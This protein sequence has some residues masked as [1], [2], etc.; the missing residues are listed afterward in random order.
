MEKPYRYSDKECNQTL[1]ALK[2]ASRLQANYA[3]LC[4]IEDSEK[5]CSW[6]HHLWKLLYKFTDVWRGL[7]EPVKLLIPP[8]SP[9]NETTNKGAANVIMSLLLMHG[10]LK[11]TSN[12]GVNGDLKGIKLAEDYQNQFVMLVGDGL[13]QIRA[14]AFDKMIEES[15]Y[16]ND[17]IGT[18]AG[19]LYNRGPARWT[20]SLPFSN[21]L[22][23]F[24]FVYSTYS[25]AS[26]LETHQWG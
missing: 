16:T 10:V 11:A 15:S 21:I 26:W 13:S 18:W 6:Y 1:I 5:M 25:V 20:I 2:I 9:D 19:N 22:A 4:P 8:V 17:Q 14:K 12:Q 3:P 24:W 7:V 23:V